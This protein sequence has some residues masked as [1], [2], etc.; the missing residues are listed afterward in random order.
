MAEIEKSGAPDPTRAAERCISSTE[1]RLLDITS[2]L[3]EEG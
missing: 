2:G 3:A 1:G